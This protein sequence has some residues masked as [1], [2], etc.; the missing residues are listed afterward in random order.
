MIQ[1]PHVGLGDRRNR[2]EDALLAAAGARAVARHQRVVVPAH[3]QH[4]AQRGGLG[5]LRPRVV[6]EAQVLLRRVG[7]QIEERRA[8]LVLGVDVFGF[9]HHPQR[10]VLAAR[11]DAGRAALAEVRHEDREDAAAAGLLLFGRRE[12]RV[13]LLV[14]QRHLVDDVEELALGLAARTRSTSLVTSRMICGSGVGSFARP[15]RIISRVRFSISGRSWSIFCALARVGDVVGDG[16]PQNR[17]QVLRAVGQRGVGTDRDA[18][19]ALRAVF[20]NIERRFAPRDVLRRRVAAAR[21]HDAERRRAA[22]AGW[23]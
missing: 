23:L 1:R 20:G 18:L 22:S 15:S 2:A 21:R 8:R 6:V 4:V 16:R 3:H 10:A 14:R 19:H 5:V 17:V 7:Q 11:R 12:D 9:L 13:R